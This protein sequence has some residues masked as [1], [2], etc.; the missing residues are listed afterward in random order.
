MV[1]TSRKM[2]CVFGIAV[3]AALLIAVPSSFRGMQKSKERL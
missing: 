3:L 2:P 1:I